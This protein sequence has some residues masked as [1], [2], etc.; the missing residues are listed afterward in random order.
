MAALIPVFSFAQEA[1]VKQAGSSQ[2][3]QSLG[4]LTTFI[5]AAGVSVFLFIIVFSLS[6]AVRVLSAQVPKR[7]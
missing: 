7:L 5:I 2:A 3:D 1:A 4:M 6:K